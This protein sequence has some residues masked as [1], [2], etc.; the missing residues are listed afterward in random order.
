MVELFQIHIKV[1]HNAFEMTEQI[2]SIVEAWGSVKDR[3]S[4][5][6]MTDFLICLLRPRIFCA[7]L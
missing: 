1:H 6:P 5:L 2:L 7:K 4:F 3:C